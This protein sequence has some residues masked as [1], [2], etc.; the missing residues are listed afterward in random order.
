M[1][2][3][4]D[5]RRLKKV[6]EFAF[7]TGRHGGAFETACSPEKVFAFLRETS[8]TVTEE[9]QASLSVRPVHKNGSVGPELLTVETSP[10]NTLATRVVVKVQLNISPNETNSMIINNPMTIPPVF[11]LLLKISKADPGWQPA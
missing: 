5:L 10:G 4:S 11:G 7:D 9:S 8:V 1:G 3:M 6:R 2:T